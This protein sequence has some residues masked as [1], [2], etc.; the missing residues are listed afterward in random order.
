M[1]FSFPLSTL[2]ND[3]VTLCASNPAFDKG[4][5]LDTF[6]ICDVEYTRCC[7]IATTKSRKS[8]SPIWLNGEPLMSSTDSKKYYY[9]YWCERENKKQPLPSCGDG[10]GPALKHMCSHGLDRTT[11]KP[12][13]ASKKPNIKGS[14]SSGSVYQA[15]TKTYALEEFKSLLIRWMV[16]CHVAFMMVE[17]EYFRELVCFLNGGLGRFLPRAASTIRKWIMEAYRREK[18]RIKL[19]LRR[20]ISGVHLSFDGWTSPNN[21]TILS[22]YAHFIDNQGIRRTWL[23][24]FRRTF[25]A[26]SAENEAAALLEIIREYSIEPG[27]FVSDN[28]G[29]NDASIDIVCSELYPHLTAAQR[30]GRRLRCLG[31]VANLCARALLLGAGAGKALTALKAKIAKGAVDAEMAFW[32]K[33]GPVG[34]LHNVVRFIRASPQRA[35]RF[36]GVIMGGALA[37]FD[38]LMVSHMTQLHTAA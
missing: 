3:K 32:S 27:Y 17:N 16:Y 20:A 9:C 23:I 30:K 31:H 7:R 14:I 5:Q 21:Y 29:T 4:L 1:P 34:M 33:R 22:V 18:D 35:E 25:G 37:E 2:R 28:L 6:V 10:N 19:E 12:V 26:H 36:L 8:T 13:D 15:L 11:G 38:D 24:A